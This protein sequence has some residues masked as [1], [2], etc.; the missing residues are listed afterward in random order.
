MR[1][2]ILVTCLLGGASAQA[3]NIYSWTDER[4]VRQFSDRPVPGADAHKVRPAPS[5]GPSLTRPQNAAQRAA[6]DQR[7]FEE[8]LR[9]DA[10][11]Q[12]RARRQRCKTLE[13]QLKLLEQ[14][15]R[16]RIGARPLDEAERQELIGATRERWRLSCLR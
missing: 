8:L 12:E 10:L 6:A 4:G 3:G 13:E 16:L 7:R 11:V 5:P 2:L 14:Q 9:R 1:A 15:P